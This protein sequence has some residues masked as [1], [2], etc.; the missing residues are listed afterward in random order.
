MNTTAVAPK[1]TLSDFRK[2][3]RRSLFLT[4]RE[5]KLFDRIPDAIMDGL[6]RHN[7]NGNLAM[8]ERVLYNRYGE[9]ERLDRNR[10]EQEKQN[11]F[12]LVKASRHISKAL[13]AGEN[14]LFITDNDN[15]GSLSQS[16]LIEF[17][18]ILP[19]P[20][21]SQ[22]HVEYA[23]PIGAA[24]GLT[25]DIVEKAVDVRGWADDAVFTIVT[26]DNG[27]NNRGEQEK[28]MARY[29]RANLIITDHHLPDESKVVLEDDRTMIFNPKYQPTEYFKKK[30]I[31]GANTLGVLL[32]S[33]FKDFTVRTDNGR[34][35][36][37]APETQALSNI[38]E[39]GAWAN[40][41]DYANAHM[42]DMPTRP[43]TIDKAVSLRPLLNVSTSMSNLITGAF[44]EDDVTQV[45]ASAPGLDANDLHERLKNVQTLN[46]FA[47]KLLNLYHRYHG[48]N[49]TFS[50]GDFYALLSDEINNT[51][52]SYQSINPNYIEQL[53]PAI[54][55]LA[56]ID[57]KDMFMAVMA[58][59][60]TGVYEDLRRQERELLTKLREVG[61]LRQDRRASST[62][63]YP[64]NAGVT[65][66]FNRRLLGKAYNE[67]NNGFLLILS[68][69]GGKEAS[70][71]MRSLYPITEILE[72]KE[73][74]EKKLKVSLDFQGHEQAAG[75][76]VR[77]TTNEPVTEDKL[78]Q[79]NAWID[80]RVTALKI[81]DRIN[82]LPNL[83]MDFAS[84]GLATKIN[85]AVKANLAGM[86]G[87]PT[88]IRFSPDKHDQVWVTDS[89][90]TEQIN[91]AEVVRR[92]KYG[93]QAIATDFDGG[94][95]V[96]PIELLRSVVDSGYKLGLRLSYMNEGVFMANQVVD[97][98]SLP[99]LVRWQGG[100]RDQEQLADYY[101][102]NFKDSH[103]M[104]LTR[105]DFRQSPYFRFNK[106]GETEFQQWESLII[107]TL[108]RTGRDVMAVVDTEGT[109]LG[110]APKC[111][112]IGGT[113]I[114][115]NPASG[116][117]MEREAF[118]EGYFRNEAG[119]EFLLTAEQR[120]ALIALND[121]EDG[122]D[123]VGN[124]VLLHKTSLDQGI[125]Y[126]DRY[127]FP[128]TTEDLE[129]LTNVSENIDEGTVVYNR[130]V[131]GFAFAY[132]I[133]NKDFAVTKE[134]E[135]LTGIGNWMVEAY[136][137]PAKEVDADLT[138]Y[139]RN[140]KGPDGQPAKII[141][142]AHNMPYDKGVVSANF[143]KL[144]QLM[145]EH[146]TSDTA[147]IA[148]LEKL[149]YD[150][151]PVSSY[152]DVRGIP[153]KAYFYDSPYSDYSLSTF[154]D[155]CARGKGGVFPDTKAKLLLRY[156]SDKEMFSLIDREANRE[157]ELDVSIATLQETRTHG[158]LPNNAVKYSVERLSARTMIRNIL[159]LDKPVSTKVALLPNEVPHR[160]A[161]EIFQDNY[162]FD[163]TPETNIDNFRSSLFKNQKASDLLSDVDLSDL[164]ERF[165]A[166]NKATQAKFHDGWI[167]E[168]VLDC[169]EPSASAK[170]APADIVE[171][172]NYFTDLPSKK[173]RKVLEDVVKF[174]RHFGIDVPLVHEQHNNIRQRSE[175]G[176][177]LSDT[178]YESILP[179]MLA[180]MR[181]Y[182]PYYKSNDLAVNKL[183]EMN[184]KGS[185]IQHMVGDDFN[186]ELA[187]DSYSVSQMLAFRRHGKTDVVRQAQNMVKGPKD[188]TKPL[189][190]IKLKLAV[191][192]L[193]P[194]S[195]IYVQPR[196]HL[197]QEEVKGIAE[198][199]K[200]I[201]VNEQLKSTILT[202]RNLSV[203]HAGRLLEISNTN[204]DECMRLRDEI[205]QLVEKVEYNRRD[206]EVK[207]LS[208]M[209]KDLFAG[210]EPKLPRNFEVTD[211]MLEIAKGMAR[212]YQEI[213][214]KLGQEPDGDEIQSFVD[215]LSAVNIVQAQKRLDKQFDDEEEKK[216]SKKKGKEDPATLYDEDL[217][218]EARKV[219]TEEFLP[220]LD[221]QRREPMKF[222]LN[223]YGVSLFFPML[224]LKAEE[225]AKDLLEEQAVE[226]QVET[227]AK[228]TRKK[229]M[230][231]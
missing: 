123:V 168:K 210:L 40:L 59:T 158:Q 219:R 108:D 6:L 79:L 215:T 137:K 129:L 96:V 220:D 223:H 34:T 114:S 66:L 136:G 47:H 140:L 12:N 107:H 8:A 42:A 176:Q 201:V 37:M 202:T 212:G 194:G 152:E 189:E 67:D 134:F 177:G 21:Q 199:L 87:L 159:L 28:I 180:M 213:F 92:K 207:K 26:A 198:K 84:V 145:D 120:E 55:N 65:K 48:V 148:R 98:E 112:N 85:A 226:I 7:F 11:I 156:N 149:A 197:S 154:L 94:A 178:A 97:V 153:P 166:A 162:H 44:T 54:F 133:N 125:G 186:N 60:M 161:L 110:K 63:L 16:I 183:I 86:W 113:N 71:S 2:I 173:I 32:T 76:F 99:T 100:R 62:I 17:K 132:L 46:V 75:F 200:F 43:Y 115:I 196:R 139:Y 126:F 33:T 144:N 228:P 83:E 53:R 211:E 5:A 227:E 135:D 106:F 104:P 169:Y 217:V 102:K 119:R 167:Y 31:S 72:G 131:H 15:D 229:R 89:E 52:D 185:L 192:I 209:F 73:A 127:I 175:D 45:L 111:F 121:D 138:N 51:V 36:L 187:R 88:V 193:P 70:G 142:Q 206:A 10:L 101:A 155:R 224:R 61:L 151:T 216:A 95:F 128:G 90:T 147:K 179:Q 141:F 56:A 130:Q 218:A 195:A 150:S 184:M 13:A 109:G 146:I 22:V 3:L 41:L 4:E 190:R 91:L 205:M 14:V 191:D 221:I 118:E 188:S 172:I 117:S 157:V 30:N 170:R 160:A 18:K 49:H 25:I 81:A 204:N 222:V 80:E 230:K 208:D 105:E 174:N 50:E 231:A 93:Y 143:Q 164:A 68:S 24:R 64:I 9:V 163:V 225:A 182:N 39:I 122:S 214:Y 77:S 165:L 57:N 29:T 171:Q 58:D 69:F 116:H 27:I 38:E 124:H 82:Q 35:S 1:K 74:I 23:Q 103:F 20:V 181:F 19:T 78:A 203:S